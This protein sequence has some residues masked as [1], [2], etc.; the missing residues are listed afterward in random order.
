ML[1]DTAEG[2]YIAGLDYPYAFR[3]D[4]GVAQNSCPASHP[5]FVR[6]CQTAYTKPTRIA[7]TID[8]DY[9]DFPETENE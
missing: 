4:Q 2:N 5:Y 3:G 7:E 6:F 9:N 8:I 1:E